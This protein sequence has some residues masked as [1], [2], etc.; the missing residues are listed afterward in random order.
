MSTVIVIVSTHHFVR[1]RHPVTAS[2]SQ[3][4]KVGWSWSRARIASPEGL[5]GFATELQD[6]KIVRGEIGFKT[7]EI[8]IPFAHTPDMDKDANEVSEKSGLKRA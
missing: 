3:V 7:V 1:C 2:P 6:V 5:A 8:M 4:S